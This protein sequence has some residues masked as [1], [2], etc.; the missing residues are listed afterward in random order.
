M[1]GDRRTV[2]LRGYIN[3]MLGAVAATWLSQ[4]VCSVA[5][6]TSPEQKQTLLVQAFEPPRAAAPQVNRANFSGLEMRTSG[7]IA[8]LTSSLSIF[9]T[10]RAVLVT[11][12]RG[13]PVRKYF[14][15]T[16]DEY[17]ELFRALNEAKFP[18]LEGRYEQR[19]LA[20]GINESLTLRLTQQS[21][22]ERTYTVE[23]YG[24]RA[25]AGYYKVVEH[26]RLLAER[27][28]SN[29]GESM[30][31]P[32][33]VTLGNFRW[34]QWSIRGAAGKDAPFKRAIVLDG[35][36]LWTAGIG[37]TVQQDN[38]RQ[39]ADEKLIALF[40]IINDGVAEAGSDKAPPPLSPKETASY[41]KLFLRDGGGRRAVAISDSTVIQHVGEFLRGLQSGTAAPGA[42]N[43]AGLKL[44]IAT[45]EK[46]YGAGQPV[47][48]AMSVRNSGSKPVTINFPSSQNFDI[49]IALG[50]KTVWQWSYN[51]MFGQI[52]RTVTL[53]PGEKRTFTATWNQTTNDGARVA[54]GKY[55]VNAQLAAL[56]RPAFPP[57]TVIIAK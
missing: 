9:N 57:I 36:L 38:Q 14:T 24:D 18:E 23:N 17:E 46:I 16:S 26:L 52:F 44:D 47:S 30:K 15:L 41:L 25:P 11:G 55:K 50:S 49:T 34:L 12:G 2:W 6:A 53:A 51:R 54:P 42:S 39:L 27:K 7:G 28:L 33:L 48:F 1:K 19:N 5:A 22:G 20:D 37:A 10:G 32:P 40:R 8:N 35:T 45:R 3:S 31:P 13:E 29:D 43:S 56:G 4:P 21:S